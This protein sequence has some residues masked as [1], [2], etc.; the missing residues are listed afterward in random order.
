[1]STGT[2]VT[3]NSRE[4]LLEAAANLAY[5]DGVSIGVEAL[6]KAAGFT[7][8]LHECSIYGN[9]AAG[10]K[11]KAMLSLGASKPWPEALAALSGEKQADASAMLDYFAPLA[12]WLKE[13]NK[14]EPCGW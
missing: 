5:Q 4:R 13:Q 9:K 6:C 2:E 12:A 3:P 14:G 10:D 8:P 1:M 11:L 7:G